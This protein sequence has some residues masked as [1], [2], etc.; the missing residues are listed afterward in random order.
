MKKIIITLHQGFGLLKYQNAE[1]LQNDIK[2]E[3]EEGPCGLK[4]M[5][6]WPVHIWEDHE[7][8][9][10]SFLQ[11]LDDLAE[12]SDHLSPAELGTIAEAVG[13][14]MKYY[15]SPSFLKKAGLMS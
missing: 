4:T 1:K 9:L 2:K 6:T 5:Y 13:K 14:F 11:A 7:E 8:H 15:F 3:A 10:D 12:A